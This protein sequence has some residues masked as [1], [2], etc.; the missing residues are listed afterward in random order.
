MPIIK[1]NSCEPQGQGKETYLVWVHWLRF[2]LFSSMVWIGR[3]YG[4]DWFRV[5]FRYPPIWKC[6]REP[7]AKQYSDS[8]LFLL[9][10]HKTYNEAGPLHENSQRIIYVINLA[11]GV[12]WTAEAQLV[13]G[14]NLACPWDPLGL[15]GG[16][17][18]LCVKALYKAQG[19]II[20]PP[21]PLFA[22]RPFPGRGGGIF[23]APPRQ[24]FCAPHPPSFIRP[25]P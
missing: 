7:H 24:E 25:H 4:L 1:K 8:A 11:G 16:R 2:R 12:V 6:I 21:S 3:Q 9:S 19:K 18:S 15:K 5:Q 17:R 23:R 22:T 14:T 13:P 20:Y 10:L